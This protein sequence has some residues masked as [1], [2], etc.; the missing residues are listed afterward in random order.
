MDTR[1]HLP[2]PPLPRPSSVKRPLPPLCAH[3]QVRAAAFGGYFARAPTAATPSTRAS[4]PRIPAATPRR[5]VA[6]PPC[7]VGKATCPYSSTHPAWFCASGTMSLDAE[8]TLQC[9]MHS[10]VGV[11]STPRVLVCRRL[12][13]PAVHA[14]RL[15]ALGRGV[16]GRVPQQHLLAASRP[17]PVTGRSPPPGAHTLEASYGCA[18]RTLKRALW[19]RTARISVASEI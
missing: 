10:P 18:P 14:A 4:Q 16:A 8:T 7:L 3:S 6:H 19:R 11:V 12:C 13:R 2:F 9:G 1:S 17:W 15:R 5:V